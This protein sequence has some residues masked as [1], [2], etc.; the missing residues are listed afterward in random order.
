MLLLAARSKLSE[1]VV[2]SHP[3][4]WGFL[5]LSLSNQLFT[6]LRHSTTGYSD[7]LSALPPRIPGSAFRQT[8]S[9]HA[10]NKLATKKYRRTILLPSSPRRHPLRLDILP[11]VDLLIL[12]ALGT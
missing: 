10:I 7:P 1:Q 2:A 3:V 8:D 12:V 5:L 9:R 4:L 6:S 11:A